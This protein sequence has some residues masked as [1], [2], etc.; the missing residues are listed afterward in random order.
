[1]SDLFL[2]SFG[3]PDLIVDVVGDHT[4]LTILAP[5]GLKASKA[6][7]YPKV[8]KVIR[9]HKDLKVQL[10]LQVRSEQRDH[11]DQPVQLVRE[12]RM[13]RRARRATREIQV[14][15]GHKVRGEP[16]ALQARKA[17][18]GLRAQ[19]EQP[20]RKDRK[21]F[22]GRKARSAPNRTGG[23]Q[24]DGHRVGKHG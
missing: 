12:V 22:M 8:I 17:P 15:K 1:M 6:Y 19:Q 23:I 16:P 7:P 9:D 14:P 11:K 13:A 24:S 2:T 21:V 10:A 4:D 18:P 5:R 20:A 3:V